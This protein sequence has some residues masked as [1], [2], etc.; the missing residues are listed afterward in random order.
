MGK[1]IIHMTATELNRYDIIVNLEEGR[2]NG[3][4][5]AKQLG[6]SVRHTKRL[7]VA[8]ATGGVSALAHG[9]RGKSSNRKL[10]GDKLEKVKRHLHEKYSDFG[11]KLAA[12]KLHL[13]DGISLGR[14]SVRQIMI[15]E[16]LWR[17]RS[18]KRSKKIHT[19]R[20]RKDNY[21]EM[22]QFDGSYHYWLEGRAGEMCLLLT[23]D[24]A[25]GRVTHAKFDYNEGKE[26][27]FKFW[28]EYL[29]KN[30]IP[31]SVY[32]DKYST[33]KVNHKHAVDNSDM[34]TEFQRV[35]EQIGMKLIT[36]HSP[37]AKGRVERM[38]DTLQDRMVKEMRLANV[39]TMKGANEFLVEYLPKLNEMFA[40]APA[41]KANLHKKVSRALKQKL[42]QIFSLQEERVVHNDY[43]V[44]Y[45]NMYFQLDREQ[46]TT[47]FKKDKVLVELHLDGE[48]KLNKKGHYLKYTVLPERPKKEIDIK[49]TALTR[50]KSNWK[51]PIDHPWRNPLL[52]KSQTTKTKTKQKYT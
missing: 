15:A 21:G 20:A 3:T 40:V 32:L 48:I 33:Y 38:F 39:S 24:D 14:E 46:P 26:A 6:V 10:K 28:L 4:E 16:N 9:N 5:A 11:P 17:A 50:K 19:W 42:P 18:R 43:T 29:E 8:V 13:L 35:A 27:V 23:I 47:V 25:T 2:I 49:L 52:K 45:K 30:D 7:K 31:L 37:Q 34:I 51:P 22:Q 1:D 44:Q 12:E 41:S 36:A